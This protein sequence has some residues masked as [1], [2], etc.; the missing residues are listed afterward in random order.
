MDAFLLSE[1]S[2]SPSLDINTPAQLGLPDTISASKD[3]VIEAMDELQAPML[4]PLGFLF[5]QIIQKVWKSGDC[6]MGLYLRLVLQHN[7]LISLQ[8]I[9]RFKI[10][11]SFS[12]D[13]ETSFTQLAHACQL[14]EADLS[15]ILRHAITNRIFKEPRKGIVAHTAASKIL[16]DNPFLKRVDWS[17]LR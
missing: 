6:S 12:T 15:R 5:H 16:A 4:G 17:S 8:A 1:G 3:V 2:P 9:Y 13:E 14:N 11:T 10:A 7:N